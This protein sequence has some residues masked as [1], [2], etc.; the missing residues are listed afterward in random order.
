VWRDE[1]DMIWVK[2]ERGSHV[3]LLCLDLSVAT[4]LLGALN[5]ALFSNE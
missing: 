5:M 1:D 4:D 3:E 2:E